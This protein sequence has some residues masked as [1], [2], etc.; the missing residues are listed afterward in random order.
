[1]VFSHIILGVI[2]HL[3]PV[4]PLVDDLVGERAFSRVVPTVDVVNFLHHLPSLLQTKASQ[5]Q[6][7]VET[8]V[9]FFI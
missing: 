4:V 9:G 8:K 6:V 1:L 2:E 3:G 7:E 5:I